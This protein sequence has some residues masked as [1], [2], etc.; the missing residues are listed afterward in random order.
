[1][2]MVHT[3]RAVFW[4]TREISGGVKVRRIIVHIFNVNVDGS[5]GVEGRIAIVFSH[6]HQVEATVR[7]ERHCFVIEGSSREEKDFALT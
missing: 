2:M 7:V 5:G 3:S 6:H 1:M 4:N